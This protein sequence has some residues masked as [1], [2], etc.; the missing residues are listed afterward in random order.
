MAVHP[1]TARISPASI[2]SPEAGQPDGP[3]TPSPTKP[4]PYAHL[5]GGFRLPNFLRVGLVVRAISLEHSGIQPSRLLLFAY[6]LAHRVPSEELQI[7]RS[8][9]S[10]LLEIYAPIY[11]KSIPTFYPEGRRVAAPYI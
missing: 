5:E 6:L 4:L 9:P 2:V 3:N 8:P 7:C 10:D 1:E 11:M